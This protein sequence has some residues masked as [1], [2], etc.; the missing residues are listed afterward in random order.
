M[1]PATPFSPSP[2]LIV[3]GDDLGV[4]HACNEAAIRCH[5]EGIMTCAEV[6]V[7]GPW[8]LES[9]QMLA[10]T[11]ALDVGVHLALT[12]EWDLHKWRPLSHCPSLVDRDGYFFPM[13]H[14]DSNYPGRSVVENTW[15]I[16]EVEREFRAQIELALRHLPQATHISGHM[17]CTTF[18][19]EVTELVRR[20]AAE[21]G[22][23]AG[24]HE[25]NV[26]KLNYAGPHRTF[27][28]KKTRFLAV[29]ATLAPG[30]PHLFVDHPGAD[31]GEV[32]ALHNLGYRD[33][34]TDRQG[35]TDLWTDPEIIAA[36]RSHR[37]QLIR[38]ADLEPTRE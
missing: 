33:V 27:A 11:P 14:P 5:R 23:E 7:P 22:L 20:L 15:K 25:E 10:E 30:E 21:F 38:Y 12:S 35:V 18:T 6:L 34:A 1:T 4:S 36:L 32:R 29:L 31:C 3:R 19:P 26:R 28:E 37:I 13:L 2:R 8:F 24:L 9:A 16:E 17:G